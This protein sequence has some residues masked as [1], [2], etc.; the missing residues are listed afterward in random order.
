VS[1]VRIH[2]SLE[3]FKVGILWEFLVFWSRDIYKSHARKKTKGVYI[4]N[5]QYL[6]RHHHERRR[7]SSRR[8]NPHPKRAVNARTVLKVKEEQPPVLCSRI[9]DE[10]DDLEANHHQIQKEE[11]TFIENKRGR[12]SREAGLPEDSD[13]ELSPPPPEGKTRKSKRIV[14]KIQKGIIYDKYK[15]LRSPILSPGRRRNNGKKGVKRKRGHECDVCEKVFG[16]PSH[17]ARHMHTHTNEKPYE[18]DVCEKC[19][20]DS[21]NLKRHKRIHTNE[22]AYECDVCDKAFRQATHLEIHMRIHTNEKPY[23]CDVCEKRFTQSS[24]LK[25]HVRI[26]TNEK[27]YECHV[28][29]KR[30]RR[31]DHLKIHMRRYH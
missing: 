19:F 4:L 2:I 27:P 6:T 26:H 25:R 10:D 21:G 17:L 18:C 29:E 15:H 28:C 8:K 16:Y 3:G 30:Y 5:E 9:P 7:M 23:E 20:S 13:R 12:L 14:E 1:L 11:T 22:K 31:S 24:S